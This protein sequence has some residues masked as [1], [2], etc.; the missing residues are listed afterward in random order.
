MKPSDHTISQS[1]R[2]TLTD[3]VHWNRELEHVHSRIAPRFARPEPWLRVLAYLHG[4]LSE[5][6]RK[7]GWQI[8]EHAR[9][10]RPD[11][12]Q[13]L[14]TSTVWDAN[15]VRDDLRTYVLERIGDVQA[16]LAIDETSFPK[17]GRKSVGV[18]RQYCGTAKRLQNCQVG[19]FVS[20]IGTQGHTLL[21][22]ELYIPKCWFEDSERCREAGI[23]ET[24]HFQTKCE[25][26]RRMLE[27]VDQAQIPVA[28]VVADTV[29]G[30]NQ[31]LRDWLFLHHSSYVLAVR[32]DEPVE[33]MTPQG[34]QRMTVAEA[35]AR[36]LHTH[37]WQRLSMGEGTKGPRWFD[38]AVL[39]M[40]YRCEDD[41]RH[42]LLIRRHPTDAT[43][44]KYY[45][46][47][48]PA[49]T[50][51]SVMV[52]AIGAR[53]GIEEDFQTG[54]GLGLDQYEVRTWTAW[55]R[56]ITLVMLA[57]AFLTSLCVQDQAIKTASREAPQHALSPQPLTRPEMCHLLGHLIWPVPHNVSF[58]LAWSWWRRCHQRR[59][60]YYHIRRRLKAG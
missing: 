52:N 21:D 36:F 49:G 23:P 3:V 19:V 24:A 5:I 53:W 22:R 31:D 29:Y 41:G 45:V 9:E 18:K 33:I 14:L 13:R 43:D 42:W 10:A 57:L 54:K 17:Q 15:L 51:L 27:R 47:F 4:L 20:Y 7:N 16:I 39:P 35:Q 37:D 59:A 50:P 60:S 38:W 26:A 46:V 11:G 28:W 55:Y 1:T 8:A 32:C 2:T 30:S 56:H 25:L 40:L 44:Q 48:S 58:L 6:P 12:M 34:R